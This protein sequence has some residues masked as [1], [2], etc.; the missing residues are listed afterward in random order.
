MMKALPLCGACE[1]DLRPARDK[2]VCAQPGCPL[3][4]QEQDVILPKPDAPQ[5]REPHK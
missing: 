1:S 3:Y 5:K 4:G 2:W